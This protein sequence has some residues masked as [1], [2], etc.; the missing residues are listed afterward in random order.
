MELFGDVL[1]EV[2]KSTYFV[3][4]TLTVVEI[5]FWQLKCL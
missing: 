3:A 2:T 5:D 1:E 4:T